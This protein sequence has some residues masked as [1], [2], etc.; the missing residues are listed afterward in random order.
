MVITPRCFLS[1]P[2]EPI[3]VTLILMLI[4]ALVVLTPSYWN[5]MVTLPLFIPFPTNANHLVIYLS[6][7][8]RRL[9]LTVKLVLH[10]YFVFRNRSTLVTGCLLRY[11]VPTNYET[12]ERLLR[13]YLGNLIRNRLIVLH[14]AHYPSH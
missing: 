14:L 7:L 9:G 13:I 12:A 1:P 3:V 5:P 11:F 8:L 10:I 2:I 6:V 4:L